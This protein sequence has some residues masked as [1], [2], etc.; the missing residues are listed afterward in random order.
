MISFYASYNDGTGMKYAQY[1]LSADN[2]LVSR[3]Q[4]MA[5]GDSYIS[6]EGTFKY[7]PG[8]DTG[9]N[10]C[11]VSLYSYP[12]LIGHDL[13]Y[14]SYHSVACSGATTDDIVNTSP[15]Y[16][17][18]AKKYDGTSRILLDGAGLSTGYLDNF[19]QGYLDQLDFVKTYRPQTITVSIGGNDMGFSNILKTCVNPLTTNRTCYSTYE[20]RLELINL[21]NNAVFPNLVKTYKAIGSASSANT[22]IYAI[23]YP[24]I[25][26][27]GGNCG[28][29]VALNKDELVF[30]QQIVNY[31]DSVIEQAA[32]K[33]G[34]Y[35]VD[36]QNAFDGHRLCEAGLGDGIA[37]NG[38][39]AGN[40][41]P[42]LLG[43]PIGDESYHPTIYGYQLLEADIL[44]RTNNLTASMPAPDPNASLASVD[45][46]DILN[47][48]HSGRSINTTEYDPGISADLAFRG[49]AADVNIKG[50]DHLMSSG[51]TFKT[52]LHSDPIVLG[53]FQTSAGGNLNSNVMIPA[54]APTGYH[55]LH[56]Y[57]QDVNGQ[58]IDIYKYIY[59]ANTADDMDGDGVLDSTQACI[60]V[61]ASGQD[62]DKDGIDDACDGE[63]TQPTGQSRREANSPPA[64]NLGSEIVNTA[65][66]QI[67]TSNTQPAQGTNNNDPQTSA[68][69]TT[70]PTAQPK[71]LGAAAKQSASSLEPSQNPKHK[72]EYFVIGLM[73]AALVSSMLI[74]AL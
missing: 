25:A 70:D 29:N 71:V 57:G 19:S 43:G 31:L 3:Q 45:S 17:G 18:Q 13:N 9:T 21:I 50:S 12:Y 6:G 59:I 66:S 26:L 27:A 47:V 41:R 10:T 15:T 7:I 63:I 1:L 14:D 54:D 42:S 69:S 64:Q 28:D 51:V 8:T 33:A 11:H 65:S 24:Q 30:S 61:P 35:Y 36:T 34:I 16:I 48:P 46:S 53:S 52:E 49:A 72:A 44:K 62:Y 4:Y 32:A 5:L 68:G 2:K 37:V 73:F 56:F 55:V 67:D 74:F 40:D 20:D 23:G 60:G 58:P 38:L 39:T 22:R